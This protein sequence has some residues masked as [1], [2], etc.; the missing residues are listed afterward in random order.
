LIIWDNN[1]Q[2]NFAID[3]VGKGNLLVRGCDFQQGNSNQIHVGSN[4]QRVVIVG[5]VINGQEYI[6]ND[7]AASF[8]SGLNAAL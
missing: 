7:G 1:K 4:M 6:V 2:N 8:K 3:A 5:N